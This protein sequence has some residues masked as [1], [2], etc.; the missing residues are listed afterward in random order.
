MFY[1]RVRIADC[2]IVAGPAAFLRVDSVC[3]AELSAPSEETVQSQA[4]QALM[5]DA[6]LLARQAFRIL[7]SSIA[8]SKADNRGND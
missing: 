6:L 2:D 8:L 3:S 7:P 4:A 1:L 5:V